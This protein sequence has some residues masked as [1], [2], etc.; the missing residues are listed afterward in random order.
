MCQTQCMTDIDCYSQEHI[1]D[2]SPCL[3]N[4]LRVQVMD[5]KREVP[6]LG[7]HGIQLNL[8]AG[9]MVKDGVMRLYF[10]SVHRKFCNLL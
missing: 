4:D 6:D 3:R 1:W 7:S 9:D 2:W 10:T 5:V 8:T